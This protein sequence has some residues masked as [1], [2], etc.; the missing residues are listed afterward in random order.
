LRNAKTSFGCEYLAFARVNSGGTLCFRPGE[1]GSPKRECQKCSLEFSR[2]VAQA[3]SS[4]FEWESIS[5][6]RGGL[7]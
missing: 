2:V 6:K 3:T 1:Q 4:S 5:L 7:A